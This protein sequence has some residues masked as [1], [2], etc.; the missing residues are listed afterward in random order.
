MLWQVSAS[1]LERIF[2]FTVMWSL[3]AL[4]DLDDRAKMEEFMLNHD[5]KLK[6]PP[7]QD[8]ETMFEYLVNDTG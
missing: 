2:I 5:A 1:H 8:G 6:Y 7:V 3:G 4:L